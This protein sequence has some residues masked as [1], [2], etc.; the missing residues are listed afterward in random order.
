[1][2]HC[3]WSGFDVRSRAR[4]ISDM[5][6]VLCGFDVGVVGLAAGIIEGRV[7]T[8]GRRW[9]VSARGLV[10]QVFQAL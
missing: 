9:K 3:A 8:C 10:Q 7:V 1:M 4:L 2:S 5:V 6:D